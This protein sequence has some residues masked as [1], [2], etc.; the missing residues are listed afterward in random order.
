MEASLVAPIE[1][2][3]TNTLSQ[4]E[5][6]A[7]AESQEFADAL[8]KETV[9][10]EKVLTVFGPKTTP[11]DK[12]AQFEPAI[13]VEDSTTLDALKPALVDT[14][15]A[16]V[17]YWKAF[18]KAAKFSLAGE[19]QLALHERGLGFLNGERSNSRSYVEAVDQM[20]TF[21]QVYAEAQ[22]EDRVDE[23]Y[24]RENSRNPIWLGKLVYG[25]AGV[26]WNVGASQIYHYEE[27]FR[28]HAQRVK[29]I[30]VSKVST[31]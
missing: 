30:A 12:F 23:L 19:K 15:S 17:E 20:T 28:N 8:A 26:L 25:K 24:T 22:R 14:L 2:V 16:G 3:I 1:G 21:A 4:R 10:M 13:A 11:K 7:N 6:L 31:S 9:Y 29:A 27:S 5:K 18:L